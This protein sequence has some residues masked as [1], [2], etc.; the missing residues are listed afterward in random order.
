M[1]LDVTMPGP[2]LLQ[3]PAVLHRLP[4]KQILKPHNPSLM[5]TGPHQP[6]A[7]DAAS[8]TV[9]L[10]LFLRGRN[11]GMQKEKELPVARQDQS[12]PG[13]EAKHPEFNYQE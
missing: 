9:L 1:T 11:S 4:R 2:A 3:G 12:G 13:T 6:S 5:S 8:K 7:P 10:P